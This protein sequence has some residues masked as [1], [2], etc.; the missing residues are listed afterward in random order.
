MAEQPD[1][2]IADLEDDPDVPPRPE[3]VIADAPAEE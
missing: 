3:E 2:E 1:H